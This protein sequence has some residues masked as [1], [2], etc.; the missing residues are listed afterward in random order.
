MSDAKEQPTP[1]EQLRDEIAETREELGDTVGSLAAKADV[2]AQ[3]KENR[4]PIAAAA[5]GAVALLLGALL[6]KR[7]SSS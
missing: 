1:P 6:V 2:K 7:R 4:A 5:G 3:A